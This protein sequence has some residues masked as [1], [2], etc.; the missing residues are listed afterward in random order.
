V[1]ENLIKYSIILLFLIV[2]P[3]L[4]FGQIKDPSVGVFIGGG[5]ISGNTPSQSS[6]TG[7]LFLDFKT[8]LSDDVSFRLNFVYARYIEYFLPENRTNQ[9]YPFIKAISFK[10]FIEQ[11]L[12][13]LLYLEEGA[14]LVTINDRTF[15]D[16]NDWDYGTSFAFLAGLDFRNK[17]NSG[18]KIGLGLDYA[19]TFS[20][21]TAR[22]SSIH[23]QTQ[24]CF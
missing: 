23:F 2:F 11:K 4:S 16:I 17:N 13:S 21:T 9:Y 18:W 14:G 7:S 8:F 19:I 10:A 6:F 15:N 20:G 1:K 22:Y 12:N 5:E 24:Y 3:N